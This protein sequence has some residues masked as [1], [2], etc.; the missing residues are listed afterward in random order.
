VADE[1]D[2]FNIAT[3]SV[4]GEGTL[5]LALPEGEGKK[6]ALNSNSKPVMSNVNNRQSILDSQFNP[7]APET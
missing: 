4:T 1:D 5:T 6:G 7:T 3:Q 2:V